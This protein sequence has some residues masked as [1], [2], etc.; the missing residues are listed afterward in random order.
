MKKKLLLLTDTIDP[1]I[2]GAAIFLRNII[3][4]LSE[5][6]DVT[7]ISPY[8]GKVVYDGV[9]LVQFPIINIKPSHFSDYG[10][11]KINPRVIKREVKQCDFVLN[12]ESLQPFTSSFFAIRYAR[13]Y[14]KPFF[15]YTHAI[16]WESMPEYVIPEYWGISWI[17]RKMSSLFLR[18]YGRQFLKKSDVVIIPFLSIR[19]IFQKNRVQAHFEVAPV[20][21][22]EDFHPGKSRYDIPEKIV[23][24]Y[25]GRISR[26]KRLDVLLSA[27]QKLDAKYPDKLTL[28]IVG[29]GPLRSSIFN[30]AK[31]VTITGF[32]SHKEVAEY[33]R[34]MDI[35]VLPSI[36]E[37]S[38]IST[39]EAMRSGCACVTRD[40]GCI[41]DY[42]DNGKN[43]F[44]FTDENNLY[45]IL[46]RLVTDD[47]LREK[48]CKAARESTIKYSWKN[49]VDCLEDIINRYSAG[50]T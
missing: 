18:V 27:F 48:I 31:N 32:V 33:L 17:I 13:K 37:T 4:F 23:I 49:T 45:D 43:G 29:D 12:L 11:P 20:G 24:G 50:S 46:E 7:I 35:F 6:F 9:R 15:T 1:M 44:F 40:V 34:A 3:P 39:L 28:L 41:R 25:V 19:S 36:S 10:L 22:S 30:D 38:S 42:L 16:D 8:L 2:D 21:T 14:N 26:E 5:K 47:V